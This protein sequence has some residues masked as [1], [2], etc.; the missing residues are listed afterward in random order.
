MNK[1]VS[2]CNHKKKFLVNNDDNGSNALFDAHTK[3]SNA[4]KILIR[5]FTSYLILLE[6]FPS[7]NFRNP[8]IVVNNRLIVLIIN[9]NMTRG[10]TTGGVWGGFPIFRNG[11]LVGQKLRKG[12][13]KPATTLANFFRKNIDKKNFCCRASSVSQGNS[14]RPPPPN[15]KGLVS[16]LNMTS[17]WWFDWFV[18]CN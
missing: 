1:I 16:P 11:T 6:L 5:I 10:V 7:V 18:N 8:L 13:A 12:R 9:L 2:T 14:S 15:Q 3:H 17:P 4:W